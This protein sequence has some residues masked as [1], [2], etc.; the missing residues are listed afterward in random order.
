[1]SARANP[2]TASPLVSVILPFH[3]PG[4]MLEAAVVS[5]L[6]GTF[7]PLELLLI[8]DGS[9]DESAAVAGLLAQRDG[10]VVLLRQA[11]AGIVDALDRGIARARAPI[12]AR[13]DADDICHPER[14]ARQYRL[15]SACPELAGVS[16][17]VQ[18]LSDRPLSEGARRYFDWVNGCI[19]E[20]E[21]EHALYVESPLPHPTMMVRREAVDR[22]GGY[23]RY[24][25]PEDYDLW[26]RMS[27][28]GMRFR[29]VPEVLLFW[30]VSGGSLSRCDPRY[31]KRAFY[32]R[33]FDFVAGQ[34]GSG[35]IAAGRILRIWGAGRNG[36]RLAARLEAKGLS[37]DAYIDID[38]DKIGS[39]RFGIPVLSAE[40]VASDGDHYF[41]ICVVGSWNAREI[42][43]SCLE[44]CGKRIVRDFILL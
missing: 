12:V 31:R 10:R 11:H 23:R 39:L 16:C 21:I 7:T 27:E 15:L 8:D 25:G 44:E 26:L 22:V 24:D 28:A 14:L 34:L 9:T 37:V 41:Y 29:K 33:K 18:P 19:C 30:R 13:M 36:R 3:N 2:P 38:P 32:E 35:R 6:E 1:M 43:G 5:V 20:E 40:R 42:I 17:L 4:D